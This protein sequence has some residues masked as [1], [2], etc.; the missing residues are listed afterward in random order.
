MPLTSEEAQG[1]H[2]GADPA[3]LLGGASHL[4]LESHEEN[5]ERLEHPHHEDVDLRREQTEVRRH[6]REE[7]LFLLLSVCG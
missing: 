2:D 7:K 6:R 5:P 3:D 4:L 1:G